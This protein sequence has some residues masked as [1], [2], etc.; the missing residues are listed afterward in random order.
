MVLSATSRRQM[1][2]FGDRD[3]EISIVGEVVGSAAGQGVEDRGHDG[4]SEMYTRGKGRSACLVLPRPKVPGSII[5]VRSKCTEERLGW[6]TRDK[7]V[8]LPH[9]IRAEQANKVWRTKF[10]HMAGI[11]V[12]RA[13]CKIHAHVPKYRNVPCYSG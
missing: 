4:C 7:T 6:V 13:T 11:K 5:R 10:E 2:E 1:V 9:I 3:L 12:R 8:N